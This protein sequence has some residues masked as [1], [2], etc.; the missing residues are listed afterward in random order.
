MLNECPIPVSSVAFE[1]GAGSSFLKIQN[2]YTQ[3]KKSKMTLLL[4]IRHVFFCRIVKNRLDTKGAQ[5]IQNR[6]N[7]NFILT[8]NELS[9]EGGLH[10]LVKQRL[11]QNF[12]SNFGKLSKGN[13]SR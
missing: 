13:Q 8:S 2:S 7:G 10:Q 3:L 1:A 5:V 11:S 9:V 12:A 4:I 6:F